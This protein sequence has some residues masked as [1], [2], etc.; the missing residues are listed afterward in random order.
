MFLFSSLSV[1]YLVVTGRG[2]KYWCAKKYSTFYLKDNASQKNSQPKEAATFHVGKLKQTCFCRTHSNCINEIITSSP[3][4]A[5]IWSRASS[6]FWNCDSCGITY[7]VTYRVDRALKTEAAVSLHDSIP[8]LCILD[9]CGEEFHI[10]RTR[11]ITFICSTA[12]TQPQ[13]IWKTLLG[14][15]CA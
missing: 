2:V 7:M 8:A 5:D 1:R 3:C 10:T 14:C 13:E 11:Q 15:P 12:T 9:E 6:N 4:W